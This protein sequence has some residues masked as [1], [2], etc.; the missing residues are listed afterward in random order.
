M[1]TNRIKSINNFIDS[2]MTQDEWEDSINTRINYLIEKYNDQLEKYNYIMINEIDGLKSGGYI[3]YIN[4]NDELIWGGALC[5]INRNNIYMKK[6]N[7][8][9]KINKFKNIIFYK[10][11]ITQND[12]T[13]EIFISSLDKYG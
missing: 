5:K 13:R 8:I 9:I 4:L 1:T 12:K 2:I 10:N 3:K 7:E 6:N 11:H